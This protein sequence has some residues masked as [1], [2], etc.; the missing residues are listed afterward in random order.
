MRFTNRTVAG[1]QLAHLLLEHRGHETVVL[2]L[3]RGG[4]PVAAAVAQELGT[5]LEVLV[6]KKVGAPYH[7]ELAI[8]AV[9][10]GG[11]VLLDEALASPF[12]ISSDEAWNAAAAARAEVLRQVRSLRGDRPMVD[13]TGRTVILVDDGVA[14]GWTMRA[15]LREMRRRGAARMIVAAPVMDAEAR[16]E[17]AD[18]ADDVVCVVAPHRLVAVGRW[19]RDF[20]QLT[21]D[22]V[23][24]WLGELPAPVGGPPA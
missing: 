10:E 24:G 15:A 20:E 13:V 1:R 9:A 22:A 5:V 19:Y 8:G 3:P 11:T 17:L 23:R 4:I 14:T 16:D 2:A 21:D 6:V 7:P 12:G 18:E